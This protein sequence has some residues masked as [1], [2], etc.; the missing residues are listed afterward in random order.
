[1]ELINSAKIIEELKSNLSTYIEKYNKL[2]IDLE[3]EKQYSIQMSLGLKSSK[4]LHKLK[5]TFH[6]LTISHFTAFYPKS[7]RKKTKN[8]NEL[9]QLKD[10]NKHLLIEKHKL[11]NAINNSSNLL[12]Q[13]ESELNK[14]KFDSQHNINEHENEVIIKL[15]NDNN[16][17][18][19]QVNE[20][21]NKIKELENT[22]KQKHMK[23]KA[24]VELIA[25]QKDLISK[26]KSDTLSSFEK[27]KIE[28]NELVKQ[29]SQLNARL[30][31]LSANQQKGKINNLSQQQSMLIEKGNDWTRLKSVKQIQFNYEGN[32]KKI[33]KLNEII[34]KL[35]KEVKNRKKCVKIIKEDI[36][37][38]YEKFNV[39]LLENDKKV[40]EKLNGMEKK[41]EKMDCD[42]KNVLK[43]KK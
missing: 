30:V 33:L 43:S 17:L 35:K 24:N 25:F 5:S 10:K 42:I 11:E 20:Y 38:M 29:V 23:E 3:K 37:K 1:M 2:K 27:S 26:L 41:I 6:N 39:Y 36:I 8:E 21:K 7:L 32:N 40:N 18:S 31:Y 22:I 4:R 16:L 19:N 12:S 13:Y 9:K 14:I 28:N 34:E 15:Q